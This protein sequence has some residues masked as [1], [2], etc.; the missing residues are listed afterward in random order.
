MAVLRYPAKYF[1]LS[2]SPEKDDGD[3]L[4]Q[5]KA[6]L[7]RAGLCFFMDALMVVVIVIVIAVTIVVFVTIIASF[8]MS[9]RIA[10]GD[11]K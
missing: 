7:Y 2:R 8:T 11:G 3:C 9:F 4:V 10:T 1:S 5:Y 6:R